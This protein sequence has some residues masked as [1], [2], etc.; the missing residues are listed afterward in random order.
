MTDKEIEEVEEAE[1][2]IQSEPLGLV[3]F[4]LVWWALKQAVLA[5]CFLYLGYSFGYQ[6]GWNDLA[7]EI[8]AIIKMPV[9]ELQQR[10]QNR[11][12]DESI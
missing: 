8:R 2:A 10:Q 4:E 6:D 7:A 11:K 9:P 12:T 5:A 3:V 1:D